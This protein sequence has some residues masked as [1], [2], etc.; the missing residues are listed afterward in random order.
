M[1]FKPLY[2]TLTYVDDWQFLLRCPS[3]AIQA[4]SH[5]EAFC[6]KV[7]VQL[8]HKKTYV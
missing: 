6:A 1:F 7:D 3:H 8:D 4:L 2:Q 5:L